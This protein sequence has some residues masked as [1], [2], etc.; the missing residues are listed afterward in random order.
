MGDNK[1]NYGFLYVLISRPIKAVAVSKH[2]LSV[3]VFLVYSILLLMN[4]W[5]NLHLSN[6]IKYLLAEAHYT[7]GC[8]CSA[9]GFSQFKAFMF[10]STN[11]IFIHPLP[12]SAYHPYLQNIVPFAVC[13]LYT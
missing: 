9:P 13:S 12:Q 10:L 4:G 8:V 11:N 2:V 5:P 6:Q 1:L 7:E 3:S